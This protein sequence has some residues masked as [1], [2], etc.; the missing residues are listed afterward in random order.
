M[1]CTDMRHN[2]FCIGDTHFGNVAGTYQQRYGPLAPKSL[3]WIPAPRPPNH[4]VEQL[5]HVEAS[6]VAAFRARASF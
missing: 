3:C 5:L 2:E 6:L 1:G 4:N